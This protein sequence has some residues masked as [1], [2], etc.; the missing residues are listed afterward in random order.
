MG[1]KGMGRK[2]MLKMA[3]WCLTRDLSGTHLDWGGGGRGQVSSEE[4][5]VGPTRE[6][7]Q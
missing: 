3:S 7:S 1:G 4:G 5:Q 2:G 6:T